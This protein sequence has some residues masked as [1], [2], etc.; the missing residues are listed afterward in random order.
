[1]WFCLPVMRELK[2]FL[3]SDNS[4]DLKTAGIFWVS[5]E[6]DSFDFLEGFL[7]RK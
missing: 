5:G 4:G 2:I 7:L 3:A 6:T 1:M